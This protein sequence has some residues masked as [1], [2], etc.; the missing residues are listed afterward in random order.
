MVEHRYSDLFLTAREALRPDPGRKRRQLR[1]GAAGC[2]GGED[3]GE[4]IASRDIYARRMSP[5]RCRVCW[6]D[7]AR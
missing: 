7:A 5:K 6:P 1:P 2:C 4:I 3:D